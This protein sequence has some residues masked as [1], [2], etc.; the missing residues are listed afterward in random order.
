MAFAMLVPAVLQVAAALVP[1]IASTGLLAAKFVAGLVPAVTA[2]I[3]VIWGMTAALLASPI[4][5]IVA[6]IAA[7]AGAI[8]LIVRHWEPIRDWL[9][10]FWEPIRTAFDQ[11]FV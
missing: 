1:V 2:A 7:L 4:T 3:P 9:L 5:W 8:Y 10:S 6:G 11:G